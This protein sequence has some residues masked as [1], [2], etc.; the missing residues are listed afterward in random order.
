MGTIFMLHSVVGQSVRQL[1]LSE[2]NSAGFLDAVLRHYRQKGFAFVTMNEALRRVEE[3]RAA[4]KFISF[5]FDDGYRDNLTTVLP[6]LERYAS[7]FTVYVTTDIVERQALYWWGG[8]RE[9]VQNN[10]IVDYE[11]MGRQLP[12]CTLAQK[13]KAYYAISGHVR[14]G[15]S[16]PADVER[17]MTRHGVANS[18]LL[19]RD[20]IGR[21]DL[22]TLSRHPLVTIGGHTKTH[23]SLRQLSLEEASEEIETNRTYLQDCIDASVR[24][25]AY[26]FGDR[27]SCGEREFS[28][29][30]TLGFD[31]GVTTRRGSL[32]GSVDPFAI[33]RVLF[34][35]VRESIGYIELQRAGLMGKGV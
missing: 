6:L 25:F 23:R 5:T 9:I 13:V 16:Q 4:D 15:A 3:R 33:P 18:D 22:R 35:G 2:H 20:M 28:L 10:E 1:R 14:S 31:T 34:S 29:V 7:P 12:A 27:Q 11:P 17:L 32:A 26:P 30:K 19:D 8:L 21:K 24:H